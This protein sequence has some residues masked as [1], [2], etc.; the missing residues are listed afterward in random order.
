M[1]SL[2]LCECMGLTVRDSVRFSNAAASI[3]VQKFGSTVTNIESVL[4]QMDYE[5]NID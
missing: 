3:V 1:A 5:K 4:K 2:I